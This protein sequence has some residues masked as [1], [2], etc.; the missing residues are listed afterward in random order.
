VPAA[1]PP[2]PPALAHSGHVAPVTSAALVKQTP[3]AK[4]DQPANS[5]DPE[6]QRIQD[7]FA[8]LRQDTGARSAFYND[9]RDTVER[10]RAGQRDEN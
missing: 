8:R 7:E 5:P 10:V 1:P 2:S 4:A 6:A 3:G 9:L